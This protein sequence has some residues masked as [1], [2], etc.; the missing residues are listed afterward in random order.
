MKKAFTVSIA[1]LFIVGA[2]APSAMADDELVEFKGGIGVDPVSSITDFPFEAA[3]DLA[4]RNAVR[5]VKPGGQPWV[6]RKFE[7]EVKD[8]GEI[9]A[10]GKG[11][12]LAGGEGIGTRGG[13]TMVFATLFCGDPSNT[14]SA[15]SS[16]AVTLEPDGDFEIED[17]LDNLPLPDPCDNPVLLI[18]VA[19]P[20]RWIAAG[21]PD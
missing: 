20:G 7:A 6:I 2:F 1:V 5:G 11:L 15:H 21:I 10:E 9:E 19:G 17:T 8:D 18:R 16:G 12:V 14:P 13:V 4:D 3:T